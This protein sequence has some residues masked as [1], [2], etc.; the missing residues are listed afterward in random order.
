MRIAVG[1]LAATVLLAGWRDERITWDAMNDKADAASWTASR[2]DDTPSAEVDKEIAALRRV[3]A[4]FRS[5]GAAKAAG[6]STEITGCMSDPKAGGMGYH[7]GNPKLIDGS[8]RV[9]EPE[10]LLYAPEKDGG[11]RLTAVEYIVPLGAWTA[12]RP[13]RLFD[14]D[15]A[16]NWTFGVWALHAWAWD[17][18]PAGMFADWNPRVSCDNAP[19]S[20]L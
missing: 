2:A 6:W 9:E 20:R 3:T 8:V 7:F 11:M 16:V 5:L 10:L 1:L 19:R 4:R 17:S 14:H 15:F 13:P 12:P 18:N